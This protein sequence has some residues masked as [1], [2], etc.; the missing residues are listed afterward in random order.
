MHLRRAKK[1]HEKIK[2]VTEIV[3]NDSSGKTGVVCIDYMQNLNLP[4]VPV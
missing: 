4:R 2:E 1:F 3:R